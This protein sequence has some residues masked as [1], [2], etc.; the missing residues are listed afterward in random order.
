MIF[1][2]ENI[3]GRAK[4]ALEL[5]GSY[6]YGKKDDPYNIQAHHEKRIS[7]YPELVYN[8][9]FIGTIDVIAHE[10]LRKIRTH[11]NKMRLDES[12][13]RINSEIAMMQE[14]ASVCHEEAPGEIVLINVG[15]RY[16]LDGTYID[17]RGDYSFRILSEAESPLTR[18]QREYICNFL[19]SVQVLLNM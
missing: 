12:Y 18:E 8:Y 17:S 16:N 3:F 4:N 10:L 2:F 1:N 5:F 9:E 11:H 15:E 14:I 19:H 6:A 13:D 7:D